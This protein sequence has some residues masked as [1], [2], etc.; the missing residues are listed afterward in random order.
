MIQRDY[1]MRMTEM[2]AKALAKIMLLKEQ[3]QYEKALDEIDLAGKELLNNEFQ[4]LKQLSDK[5][6]IKWMFSYEYF[7]PTKCELWCKLLKAEGEVLESS[8]DHRLSRIRY[9]QALSLL[10]ESKERNRESETKENSELISWLM[11]KTLNG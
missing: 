11:A 8:G 9:F 6:L 1:I 4:T 2:L 5:D 7:D 10:N 3:K